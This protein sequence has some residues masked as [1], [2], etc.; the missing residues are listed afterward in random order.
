MRVAQRVPGEGVDIAHRNVGH[1]FCR[2][3]CS[4]R[5][6]FNEDKPAT[7]SEKALRSNSIFPTAMEIAARQI[8]RKTEK[9]NS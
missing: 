6:Q 8:P 2:H 5:C 7:P 4:L 3:A 9:V 1:C